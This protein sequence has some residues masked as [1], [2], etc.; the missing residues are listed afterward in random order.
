VISPSGEWPKLPA[1]RQSLIHS[2]DI[3]D[4][5]SDAF[6]IPDKW[7]SLDE[8]LNAE[9]VMIIQNDNNATIPTHLEGT[10]ELQKDITDLLIEYSDIFRSDVST[11]HADVP[12]MDIKVDR[13]KWNS[14]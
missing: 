3:L 8:F 10:P 2:S 7:D 13:T 4:Y 11:E 9:P 5:E 6:G 12:A 14:L 1:V